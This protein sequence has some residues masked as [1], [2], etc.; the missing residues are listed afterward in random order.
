MKEMESHT[1]LFHEE[2]A[3]EEEEESKEEEE[4]D[5]HLGGDSMQRV[6]WCTNRHRTYL[7]PGRE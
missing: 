4:P 7:A 5:G 3:G 2:V 6:W 1:C